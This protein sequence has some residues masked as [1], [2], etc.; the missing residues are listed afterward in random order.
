VVR[1]TADPHDLSLLD[2]DDE[3]AGVGAVAVAEGPVDR[4]FTFARN[5]SSVRFQASRRTPPVLGR[6]R[7]VEEAVGRAAVDHRLRRLSELLQLLL[8]RRGPGGRHALVQLA[9]DQEDRRA[10]PLPRQGHLLEA[11]VE[12]DRRADR[13]DAGRR[14]LRERPAHAETDDA[15]RLRRALG[16]ERT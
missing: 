9:V 6:A 12:A 7:I 4:H 2:R 3:A 13:R 1:V 5:S 8:E 14:V 15:D 10:Q 11:A 16:R